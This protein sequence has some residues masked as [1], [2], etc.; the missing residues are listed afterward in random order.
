MAIIGAKEE[1]DSAKEEGQWYATIMECR[2]T[3]RD[4]AMNLQRLAHIANKSTMWSN[5][6]NLSLDGNP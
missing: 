1:K 3:M 4:T 2:E 5:V 6:C